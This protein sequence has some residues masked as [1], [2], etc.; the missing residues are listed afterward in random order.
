MK[1]LFMEFFTEFQCVGGECPDTCCRGWNIYVD[2]ESM[3]KYAQLPEVLRYQVLEN[4]MEKDGKNMMKLDGE[5][6]CP[7][8][9]S[10]GLC[11]LYEMIS[12]DALCDTCQLYPRK[13][14]NYYDTMML[15]VSLSCPEVVRQLLEKKDTL[16]FRYVEDDTYVDTTDADWLWYNEL[17]NGLVITVE[18]LQE[19]NVPLWKRLHLVLDISEQV[20]KYA[21][22][23]KLADLRSKIQIYKNPEWR[24]LQYSRLEKNDDVV[25]NMG[26]FLNALFDSISLIGEEIPYVLKPFVKV[27]LPQ[28]EAE[29]L[30]WIENFHNEGRDETEYEKIAIQLAFEYYMDA[31]NGVALDVNIVKILVYLIILQ[32]QEM[33]T[34]QQGEL[35]IE[36]RIRLISRLSKVLEHSAMFDMVVENFL[37]ANP[38]ENIYGLLCILK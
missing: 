15:T 11:D 32:T 7:F 13:I 34:L 29:F 27:V 25:N 9:N 22:E 38:R 14:V 37:K 28:E 20:Q 18:I 5:G 8:L 21:D 35:L 30:Q 17:I 19:R 6:C 26:G 16:G 3:K 31:V 2:E 12:P 33:Y 1:Y 36:D 24:K 23:G 10:C 4:I